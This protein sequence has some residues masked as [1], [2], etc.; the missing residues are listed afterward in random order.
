LAWKSVRQERV[1]AEST[2]NVF[3]YLGSITETH[4]HKIDSQIC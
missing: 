3:G 2:H 1:H 4:T